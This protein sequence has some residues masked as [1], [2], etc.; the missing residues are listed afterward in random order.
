MEHWTIETYGTQSVLTHR[1][2]AARPDDG[3]DILSQDLGGGYIRCS[4]CGD[5]FLPA[6]EPGNPRLLLRLK[7]REMS[8]PVPD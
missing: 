4:R 6:V 2:D 7:A 8:G 5:K 1:C 3:N